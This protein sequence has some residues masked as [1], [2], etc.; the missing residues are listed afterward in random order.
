MQ[1]SVCLIMASRLTTFASSDPALANGI[2]DD[3]ETWD[4]YT[5]RTSGFWVIKT[6]D[7][8]KDI[9]IKLTEEERE[10]MMREGWESDEKCL[11][12]MLAERNK[13]DCGADKEEGKRGGEEFWQKEEKKRQTFIEIEKNGVTIDFGEDEDVDDYDY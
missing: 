1:Q 8:E 13:S 10:Q 7:K 3:P 12:L 5:A 4:I 11:A 9:I 6:E 2:P